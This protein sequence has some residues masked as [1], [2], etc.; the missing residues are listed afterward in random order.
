[1]KFI[2][3][4]YFFIIS[5]DY[6]NTY[7]KDVVSLQKLQIGDKVI[8][9]EV[10][11]TNE[12]R[13]RGLMYRQSLPKD[14][15]M[16]FVFPNTQPLSFWMKNTYIP[17]SIGFFNSERQLL[18]V[19]EMQPESILLKEPTKTYKSRLPA[20]YALEMNKGWFSRNKI[21]PGVKFKYVE[22]TSKTKSHQR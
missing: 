5:L 9:V 14:Q 4:L 17:L 13:A 2:F 20:R 18:E 7:A 22:E 11:D 16:L 21:K 12:K 8:Q 19:Q 10:A 15:G 6:D 3:L 1:M